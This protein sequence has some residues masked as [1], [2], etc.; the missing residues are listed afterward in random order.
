MNDKPKVS[1]CII[2]YNQERYIKEAIES[3]FSQ[4]YDN[5]EIIISDDAS[6]DSTPLIIK[7][8]VENYNGPHEV[9]CNLNK[10]N[11]GIRE[12]CNKILYDIAKGSIILLAGGDDVSMP[13]RTAK[14]VE[15]FTKF[16]E[17]MSVSCK[18]METDEKMRPL[19]DAEEYDCTYSVLNVHDY[20]YFADFVLFPGDSR[21]IRREVIDNFPKLEYPSAEDIYLFIRSLLLGSVCYLREPLVKRRNHNSNFSKVRTKRYDEFE[22]QTNADIDL[23][24]KKGYISESTVNEMKDKVYYLRRIFEIYW[25]PPT[26]SW[27]TLLYRILGKVFK[28]KIKMTRRKE[29]K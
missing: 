11:L 14:Y 4:E 20:T 9:V 1:F 23:A 25:N 6:S 7:E 8:M 24:Y 29:C 28:V 26:S 12:H 16:P 19:N 2:T 10:K 17:V 27:T 3:A 5:L 18:S 15:I 13:N 21:G 22:K